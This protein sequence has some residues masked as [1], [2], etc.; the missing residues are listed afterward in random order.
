MNMKAL[1][2]LARV[3]A[4]LLLVGVALFCAFGFLATYEYAEAARRLPWQAGYGL[5]GLMALGAAGWLLLAKS[6]N[7]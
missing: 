4:A 7:S 5:F 1:A 6:R 3:F 2:L